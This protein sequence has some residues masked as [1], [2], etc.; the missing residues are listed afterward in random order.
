MFKLNK[1]FWIWAYPLI[2]IFLIILQI[3]FSLNSMNQIRY[4]EL[5]ESVRNV[6]WLENRTI[7]DG[8]SSNI[9]WYGTLLIF[10]KMFGFTLFGA[11]YFRLI[12]AFISIFCLATVLK[13]YLGVQRALVPLIAF[14]LSP[15]LLYFN[16][17]QT[18]YGIDLQYFPICLYLIS[19]INFKKIWKSFL[20]QCLLGSIVMI[21]LMSY[22]S[23]IFY[24]PVLGIL[25]L[26]QLYTQIK[27]TKWYVILS[28]IILTGVSFLFPLLLGYLYVKDKQLLIYDQMTK[29]GI[30]RGAG[31]FYPSGE[32]FFKNFGNLLG[33]LFIRGNSYYYELP[34]VD[35]SSIFSILTIFTILLLGLILTIT[36]KKLRFVLLLIWLL[37]LFD[38]LI[39][40]L[41]FD[42]TGQ[43]GIR[44]HTS[45]LVSIYGLYVLIWFW[46][47]SQKWESINLRNILIIILLL[48][49]IH[50]LLVY[51]L[52][53]SSFNHSS[54][55]R[56]S[57]IFENF[58]YNPSTALDLFVKKVGKQDLKLDC[59]KPP[60][61]QFSNCRFSESFPAIAGACLWNN[62]KCKNIFGYDEKTKE[63]I[64]L[65]IDIWE[66]Y[67]WPH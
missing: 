32:I 36:H 48:L 52:N 20:W 25:Y 6:F 13:K 53:Y 4:E 22:P 41:T 45:L 24:L 28:S 44:R 46:V 29:S 7:Y 38:L 12:L 31:T 67:Y 8:V 54:I 1:Q 61:L 50:H 5:A 34:H 26:W 65:S 51:P 62:L 9:G 2:I 58:A 47:C 33:D 10:Y 14:G 27:N 23:F 11:K 17:M 40:N 64:P 30:F 66:K 37:F 3:L 21:A 63:Y 43:S 15:T 19:I 18:S 16:T 35:F 56:Y 57:D 60:T 55:Y 42:P 59:S 39:S 49:P